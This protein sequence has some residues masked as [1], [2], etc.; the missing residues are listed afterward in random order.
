MNTKTCKLIGMVVAMTAGIGHTD[1]ILFDFESGTEGWG[2]FASANTAVSRVNSTHTGGGSWSLKIEIDETPDGTGGAHWGSSLNPLDMSGYSTLSFWTR[3]PRPNNTL[4]LAMRDT[5]MGAAVEQVKFDSQI[6]V[7]DT[8]TE[9]NIPLSSFTTVN[10]SDVSFVNY[11][12]ATGYPNESAWTQ[13]DEVF[14]DSFALIPEPSSLLMMLCGLVVLLG[15][16]GFST[17][18]GR[19]QDKGVISAL[20]S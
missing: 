20:D 5:T 14:V 15:A 3:T 12:W 10:L 8:W 13:G 11:K 17:R 6:T 18:R 19:L 16:R 1:V 2:S 4:Y 7:A 9:I